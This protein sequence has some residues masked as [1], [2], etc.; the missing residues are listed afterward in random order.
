VKTSNLSSHSSGLN[1][2]PGGMILP[3]RVWVAG[4]ENYRFGYQ[5]SLQDDEIYG[6]GNAYSTNF[7]ELDPRLMRWW[8]NDPKTNQTPWESPYVSMGNNPVW[9]NDVKGDEYY[10]KTGL[11]KKLKYNENDGKLYDRKG[12]EYTGN[13]EFAKRAQNALNEVNSTD[14]GGALVSAISRADGDFIIKNKQPSNGSGSFHA[15]RT[16]TGGVIYA[17]NLMESRPLLDGV[18]LLGHES[19]H[20]F[21]MLNGSGGA[22]VNSEVEAYIFE[23]VFLKQYSNQGFANLE[24]KQNKEQASLFRSGF[25]NVIDNIDGITG[26]QVNSFNQ[27]VS[28]FKLGSGLNP[29][30]QDGTR[31][32]DGFPELQNY[33]MVIDRL[34]YKWLIAQ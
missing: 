10:I 12:R 3:G 30:K 31:L 15:N 9:H 21:Q 8:S 25:N 23:A 20:G 17:A 6:N 32:Y 34:F 24:N 4:A 13:D 2:D 27:A 29:M 7:R 18:R 26:E 5:G 28:N 14:I 33:K 19:F 1:Y 22:S 11:F 16:N